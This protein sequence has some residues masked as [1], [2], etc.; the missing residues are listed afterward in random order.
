MGGESS[1]ALYKKLQ[2]REN[3]GPFSHISGR[4]RM[5]FRK[6]DQHLVSYEG[7][8]LGVA[9]RSQKNSPSPK[10]INRKY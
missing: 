5:V 6:E 7:V 9:K 8:A 4:F 1:K 3:R 2:I 10:Q